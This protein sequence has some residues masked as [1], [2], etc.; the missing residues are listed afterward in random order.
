[1]LVLRHNRDQDKTGPDNAHSAWPQY[2]THSGVC[3]TPTKR[4]SHVYKLL[5]ALLTGMGVCNASLAMLLSLK[6]KLHT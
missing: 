3:D 5:T 4:K 1:M 2:T 6:I